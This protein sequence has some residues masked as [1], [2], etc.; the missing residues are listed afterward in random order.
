MGDN[1]RS[2]KTVNDI[3]H[4]DC[5]TGETE[6][7]DCRS[8][9]IE[10]VVTSHFTLC[11]KPWMCLPQDKDRIQERLCRKLHHEWYRIRSDLERSWGRPDQ[12]EGKFQRKQFYGYCD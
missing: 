8:R 2:Q 5:M 9:Q 7:E 3:V 6:C 10:D 12:G 1:P 11:Q 4:G